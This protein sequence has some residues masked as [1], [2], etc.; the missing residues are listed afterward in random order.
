VPPVSAR[1]VAGSGSPS[2]ETPGPS[3]SAAFTRSLAWLRVNSSVAA[4][5]DAVSR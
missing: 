4:S 3:T 1:A 5:S 2:N